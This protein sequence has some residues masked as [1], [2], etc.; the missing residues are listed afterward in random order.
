[1]STPCSGS[2]PYAIARRRGRARRQSY[3]ICTFAGNTAT[4]SAAAAAPPRRRVRGTGQETR[5]GEPRRDARGIGV[6][7]RVPA[8][9]GRDDRVERLRPSM[10]SVPHRR[11]GAP[12][13]PEVRRRTMRPLPRPAARRASFPEGSR[14]TRQGS[15]PQSGK[16]LA[17]PCGDPGRDGVRVVVRLEPHVE[18]DRVSAPGCFGAGSGHSSS[19]GP[20]PE[21]WRRV[22]GAMPVA[23]P[24]AQPA[25]EF[26]IP[27]GS[28]ESSGRAAIGPVPVRTMRLALFHHRTRRPR[29]RRARSRGLALSD[30]E[31]AR[32]EPPAAAAR[33]P[34]ARRRRGGRDAAAA[35]VV[36][37]WDAGEGQVG[38]R[39]RRQCAAWS[40]RCQA[41]R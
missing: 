5:D 19:R 37:C 20:R 31:V 14:N 25:P 18:V 24:A 6:A 22:R 9:R 21:G 27:G 13:N 28:A 32:A 7:A 36:A 26:R 16:N 8:A 34:P 10:C 1:M 2:R 12:R 11:A 23:R 29:G 15:S 3:A 38:G 30:V 35:G 40:R 39:R 33:S 4:N 17:A 41:R